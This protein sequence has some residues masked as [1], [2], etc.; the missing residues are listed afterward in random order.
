MNESTNTLAV[1]WEHDASY[2]NGYG[3]LRVRVRGLGRADYTAELCAALEAHAAEVSAEIAAI[4]AQHG[5]LPCDLVN[6]DDGPWLVVR[7]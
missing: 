1:E 4:V 2:G 3:Y 5:I 6:T 7:D